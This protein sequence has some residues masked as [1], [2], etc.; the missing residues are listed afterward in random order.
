MS[1]SSHAELVKNERFRVL[2]LL[3]EDGRPG[4]HDF[5]RWVNL[6]L[7]V[8]PSSRKSNFF[9]TLSK[10]PSPFTSCCSTIRSMPV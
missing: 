3:S 5:T 9:R 2:L 1:K 4:M 7:R 10:S 6:D 8:R